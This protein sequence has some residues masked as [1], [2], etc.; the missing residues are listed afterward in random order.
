MCD[1]D[2]E[3]EGGLKQGGVAAVE[4][5]DD[6]RHDAFLPLKTE[7]FGLDFKVA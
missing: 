7:V 6:K 4:F 5:L 1:A 3:A 2:L